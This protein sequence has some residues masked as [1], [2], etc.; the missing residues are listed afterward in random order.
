MQR[1]F[2]ECLN[3]SFTITLICSSC[4]FERSKIASSA[5]SSNNSNNSFIIFTVKL[6]LFIHYTRAFATDLLSVTRL[7]QQLKKN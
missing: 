1:G 7:K 4:L 6:R 3:N 5:C 2:H